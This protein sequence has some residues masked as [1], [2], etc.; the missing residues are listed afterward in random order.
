MILKI[1]LQNIPLKL[2]DNE[3]LTTENLTDRGKKSL[4]QK[5]HKEKRKNS[6]RKQHMMVNEILF[7]DVCQWTVQKHQGVNANNQQHLHFFHQRAQRG[8]SM[9]QFTSSLFFLCVYCFLFVCYLQ[10]TELTGRSLFGL[11]IC[12]FNK[13]TPSVALWQLTGY[14]KGLLCGRL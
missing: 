7:L 11:N 10:S 5:F 3:N 4:S 14:A 9:A 8:I 2:G 6:F 1:L 13:E 12:M